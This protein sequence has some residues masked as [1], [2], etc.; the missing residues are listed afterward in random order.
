MDV[1][2]RG[3]VTVCIEPQQGERMVMVVD[4]IDDRE[5][6]YRLIVDKLG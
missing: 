6:L 1:C 4:P 2:S 3:R 5:E